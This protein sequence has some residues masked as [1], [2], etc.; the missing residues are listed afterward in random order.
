MNEEELLQGDTF[1]LTEEERLRIQQEQAE[2]TSDL[3][4]LDNT[5][6]QNEIPEATAQGADTQVQPEQEP[7][8]IGGQTRE[9]ALAG[10]TLL[11]PALTELQ[12][13]AGAGIADFAVDAFNLVTRQEAPKVPEFESEIAQSV[14]EIS[15]I[16]LPTVLLSGFGT[17]GLAS[18]AK[19]VKFL[20]DPLVKKIGAT[21]F[22][23]GVGAA[24]DYT[25]EINQTDD[26][27][28]GSLKKAWPR[29]MGWIPDNIAT[30]DTDSPDVKRGKNVTEGVYLGAGS[31]ILL[32]LNKLVKGLRGITRA[33]QWTPQTEKAK[34]WFNKNITKEGTP[35]EVI[36]ASAA[37]R[38][39][40]LDEVGGYNFEKSVNP[41]EPVFG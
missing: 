21:G 12:T 30:L 38:A 20:A 7:K 10:A 13:A 32:G 39:S 22:S 33:T 41:D 37:K 31:D 40:E 26:N 24:V 23:M 3:Q 11:S 5:A 4:Q 16:V 35:E 18:K 27:L 9:E 19:N 36:E 34:N 8:T 15:S 28:T 1:Q 29:W 6:T 14:R 2:D 25:V 17:A